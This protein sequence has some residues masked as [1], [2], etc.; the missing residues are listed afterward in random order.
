MSKKYHIRERSF[1]NLRTSM[2]AYIIASVEDTRDI[3]NENEKEWKWGSVH[4]E[5]ADCTDEV[6]F[7]FDLSTTDERENSLYK[8]R[9]IAEVID[10]FLQAL[11]IEAESI[12]TRQA[13]T[14][15][16]KAAGT[17]H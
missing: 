1:L 8:I 17:V 12:E 7:E 3:P 13:F 15:L 6:S 16:A 10:A 4:L 9:K 2:R 14:P 11:E 5:L